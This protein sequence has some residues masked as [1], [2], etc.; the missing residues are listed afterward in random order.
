MKT[1][2]I[3]NRIKEYTWAKIFYLVVGICFTIISGFSDN[4][5]YNVASLFF[6]A[7]YWSCSFMLEL[8]TDMKEG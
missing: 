5:M 6:L 3:E 4:I 1:E 8:Y 7:L 2:V